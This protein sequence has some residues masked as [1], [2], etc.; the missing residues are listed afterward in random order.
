MLLKQIMHFI[1]LLMKFRIYFFF[2]LILFSCTIRKSFREV[3]LPQHFYIKV[4]AN[5]DSIPQSVPFFTA[6][7]NKDILLQIDLKTDLPFLASTYR[8]VKGADLHSHNRHHLYFT[9]NNVYYI[10]ELAEE[11]SLKSRDIT[12]KK[13]SSSKFSFRAP[14]NPGTYFITIY[15]KT[16]WE[17]GE[18]DTPWSVKTV[19]LKRNIILFVLYPLD[20]VKNGLLNGY[21]IG[22]YP[23]MDT[24]RFFFRIH[25]L[26]YKNPP[27]FIEVTKANEGLYISKHF[28]LKDFTTHRPDI[29]PKYLILSPKLLLKLEHIQNLLG[30]EHRIKIMSGFRTPW[31]NYNVS[32]GARYSQHMYG[33]AADIYVDSNDDCIMDDLN[34][35][36]KIDV[37]DAVYLAS[38]AEKVEEITGLV[39]GIGIYDWKKDSTRGP[40]VHVD[41]REF[42]ARW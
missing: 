24:A 14:K 33:K 12:F 11:I 19:Y 3:G 23:E 41:V 4:S 32:G 5:C 18:K 20:W 26:D 25:R 29:Y 40:F 17:K 1:F 10:G 31:Y 16:R 22:N 15:V 28:K 36:G 21:P 35:D 2:F 38:I 39:G 7:P 9:G 27:G 37:Q 13:I 34:E 8:K 42:R 30:E 6:L